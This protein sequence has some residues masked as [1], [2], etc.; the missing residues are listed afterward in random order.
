VAGQGIFIRS[1]PGR[2]EI[3]F[4][5]A[6]AL[7]S[8]G[9]GSILLDQLAQADSTVGI[10]MFDAT[11]HPEKIAMLDVF[12]HSG[13]AVRVSSEP[14]LVRLAFPT[15]MTE[16]GAHAFERREESAAAAAVRARRPVG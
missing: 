8:K 14:G 3:A 7:H 12:S 2:A 1:S 13:L 15:A 9:I 10:E 6:D 16:E 4:T 11:V 5:V